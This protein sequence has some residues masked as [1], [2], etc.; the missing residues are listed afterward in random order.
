[1]RRRKDSAREIL[2]PT[3]RP[4]RDCCKPAARHLQ[5]CMCILVS[6]FL[7]FISSCIPCLM[8]VSPHLGDTLGRSTK[9]RTSPDDHDDDAAHDPTAG[10]GPPTHSH[11]LPRAPPTRTA[12]GAA[13]P[14]R[15]RDRPPT[16]AA[17]RVHPRRRR[18]S[19]YSSS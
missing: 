8:P 19:L 15:R 2:L 13:T 1:M 16:R 14:P 4:E 7:L 5:Y 10:P 9:L 6:H 12:T 18:H 3:P 11:R 17:S